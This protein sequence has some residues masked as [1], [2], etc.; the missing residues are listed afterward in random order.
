MG[1]FVERMR[2]FGWFKRAG[3][4][5][6]GS[7][8]R[9]RSDW[10]A[11]VRDTDRSAIESLRARLGEDPDM[12]QDVE[13]EDEMLDALERLIALLDDLQAGRLP[14]I[15]TMHHVV[16]HDVC[17]FSAPVSMPDH[18]AQPSGRLLFTGSRAVFIGGARLTAIPWHA[19]TQAARD[20][21]DLLLVRAD[22]STAYRFRCNTYADALCATALAHH[23]LT[24]ARG[25]TRSRDL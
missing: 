15:E 5:P 14:Q 11:A 2:I 3:A 9:W 21:R 4:S 24:R 6:T 19:A 18:A 10:A 25:A 1:Y 7:R 8:K 13:V 20:D 16:A 23:L 12:A 17:H 22:L